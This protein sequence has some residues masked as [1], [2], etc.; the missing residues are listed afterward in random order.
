MVEYE[1][2]IYQIEWKWDQKCARSE[3]FNQIECKKN[4][5]ICTKNMGHE[6]ELES[7]QLNVRKTNSNWTWVKLD[8]SY[9]KLNAKRCSLTISVAA[10]SAA[11]SASSSCSLRLCRDWGLDWFG[12]MLWVSSVCLGGV[13]TSV[14]LVGIDWCL[15]SSNVFCSHSVLLVG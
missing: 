6:I 1:W 4:Q 2:D 12:V 10:R 3:H 14:I 5:P 11:A 7:N 9:A 15:A 13:V 8:E